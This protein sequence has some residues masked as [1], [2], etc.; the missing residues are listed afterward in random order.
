MVTNLKPKVDF[1]YD[2]KT[3]RFKYTQGVG[4][5]QFAS[6]EA[7]RSILQ[8]NIDESTSIMLDSCDRLFGRGSMD[9]DKFILEIA[10]RLKNI[11]IWQAALGKQG[12]TDLLGTTDQKNLSKRLKEQFTSGRDHDSGKRFGL[13]YLLQDIIKGESL[14]SLKNRIRM[15]AESGKISFNESEREYKRQQGLT[16]ARRVLGTGHEHCKPC[17]EY[18]AR[19]WQPISRA[20]MPTQECDCRMNC[21]CQIIYR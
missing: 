1:E 5:G 9:L 4:K 18:A 6:S 19:G 20:I 15:Y 13:K 12:R 17:V 10:D 16:Q 11:H 14:D 3:K 7:V 21:K 2:Q 8:R